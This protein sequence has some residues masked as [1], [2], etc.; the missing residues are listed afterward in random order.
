MIFLAAHPEGPFE[1]IGIWLWQQLAPLGLDVAMTPL[2]A[3]M[4][5][6]IDPRARNANSTEGR[7]L[8]SVDVVARYAESQDVLSIQDFGFYEFRVPFLLMSELVELSSSYQAH[9]EALCYAISHKIGKR[10]VS[11]EVRLQPSR[12][13]DAALGLNRSFECGRTHVL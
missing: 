12:E 7:Y 5:L 9:Q 1:R 8:R 6:M 2:T 3:D 13:D 10:P 4:Q 11:F